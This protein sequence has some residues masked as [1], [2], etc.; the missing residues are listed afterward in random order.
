MLLECLIA[1][2][3][4]NVVMMGEA[5]SITPTCTIGDIFLPTWGLR[6]E[7]TSYHYLS[8]DIQPSPSSELLT[9]LRHGLRELKVEWQEG[10]IWTIDA[11]FRETH[12]KIAA[13][14]DNDV[15]AVEMES[16]A[17][18]SIAMYRNVDFAAILAISDELYDK[19]WA[20]GFDSEQLK[21][22]KDVLVEAIEKVF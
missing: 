11:P 16:T 20:P 22:T 13:Y 3:L 12:E 17:L 14:A 7:G 5:G 8:P 9:S 6:E 2:G 1:T 19:T 21:R 4:Q 10:G 18:M 15:C